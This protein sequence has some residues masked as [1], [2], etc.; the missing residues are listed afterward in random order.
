MWDLIVKNKEIPSSSYLKNFPWFEEKDTE[1]LLIIS[2]KY[3]VSPSLMLF[4]QDLKM[5]GVFE[6]EW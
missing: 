1:K 6:K 2:L 5:L 3:D 4:I